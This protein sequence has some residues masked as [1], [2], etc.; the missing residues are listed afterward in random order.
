MK[1]TSSSTVSEQSFLY[2]QWCQSVMLFPMIQA[3]QLI[4]LQTPG[5]FM[6]HT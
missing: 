6:Q 3:G 2:V 1:W 4:A 5:L